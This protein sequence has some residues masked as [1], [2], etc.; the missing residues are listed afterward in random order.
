MDVVDLDFSKAFDTV[1]HS[2]PMEKLATPGLD[3]HNPLLVKYWLDGQAR[4]V[5]VN[6]LN[7]AG[8]QSQVLFPRAQYWGQLCLISLS[9]I[10]MRGLSDL[11]VSLQMTPRWA[12]VLICLRV[13]RLCRG[14]RT[15]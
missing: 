11:S 2:I 9:M 6:E 10:W 4:R 7:A 3:G 13:G 12:G 14:I 5:A 8:D 15:N 1:S